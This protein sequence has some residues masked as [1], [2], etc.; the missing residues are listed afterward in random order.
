MRA[1][2]SDYVLKG[3]LARLG[4]AVC[5]ELRQAEHRRQQR[6]AEQAASQ[7]HSERQAEDRRQQRR[8]EQAE[9]ERDRLLGQLRLQIE[10]MPLGYL[11]SG[12][13]LR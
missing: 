8:A 5:R 9:A 7:R 10:R 2:A 6:R 4:P 12:P 13:D 1:G 3:N 11:L